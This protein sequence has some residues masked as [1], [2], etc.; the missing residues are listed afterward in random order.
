MK[1]TLLFRNLSQ[2]Q[3]IFLL[4]IAQL[5][6]FNIGNL[7]FREGDDDAGFFVI[8]TG[9]IKVLKVS[10]TGKEQILNIF[11]KSENFAEIAVL[12]GKP[13]P[14]SAEALEFSELIFFS[15]EL[16]LNLLHQLPDVTINMLISL[17][18][19]SRHLARV[20][21]DLSFKNVPQRLATYLLNLSD[22][23]VN[24]AHVNDPHIEGSH[25]STS[26]TNVVT[27]DLTKNQLAVIL[28]TVPA[29][30]SRA[31]YC[32]SS[33]GSIAVNGPNIELRDRDRLQTFSQSFILADD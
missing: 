7:I 8:K 4:R 11:E 17:A 6:T 28:G 27:L 13:S 23:H 16:F 24:T 32:L 26:P 1:T 18:Q 19:H 9:R 31:F 5:K 22:A 2:S 33:E 21:E 30:L 25:L 12:D 29:T 14:A 3:L 20:I 15:R 10:P